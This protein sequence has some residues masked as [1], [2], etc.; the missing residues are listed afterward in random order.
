[1]VDVIVGVDVD[2]E[3]GVDVVVVVKSAKKV[4]IAFTY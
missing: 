1:V 4:R 2:V 3:V